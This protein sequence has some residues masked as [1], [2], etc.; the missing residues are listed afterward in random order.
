MIR[1]TLI[2]ECVEDRVEKFPS[3]SDNSLAGAA[4]RFDAFVEVTHVGAVFYGDER[5]LYQP[6]ASSFIV[7]LGDAVDELR[8]V[9]L[10][11]VRRSANVGGEIAELGKIPNVA[12]GDQ[13]CGCRKRPDALDGD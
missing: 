13:E 11:D 8:I 1:V 3:N 10:A 9:G 5:K 12:D 2:P 7:T 4:P 6:G